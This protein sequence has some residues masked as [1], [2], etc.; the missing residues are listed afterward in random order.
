MRSLSALPLLLAAG[1]LACANHGP[2][3]AEFARLEP[4]A[5][6][7]CDV[8][9]AAD[10]EGAGEAE[11]R[12]YLYQLAESRAHDVTLHPRQVTLALAV[13]EPEPGLEGITAGEV[14]CAFRGDPPYRITLYPTALMGRPLYTT[15]QTVAHEF[16][17]I[18]QI[19][20]DRLACEP[21]DG[22]RDHYEAEAKAV[23]ERLVPAC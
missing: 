2:D 7:R 18:V 13:G 5:R 6:D 23:A 4:S 8:A 19:R 21:R 1:L 11:L 9:R 14:A 17:H 16:Q 15:Y 3:P 10:F 22:T 20:R 12:R